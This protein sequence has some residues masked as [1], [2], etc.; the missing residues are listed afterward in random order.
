MTTAATRHV[1]ISGG[2]PSD[3]VESRVHADAD[4]LGGRIAGCRAVCRYRLYTR[5][6]PRVRIEVLL[7]DRKAAQGARLRGGD[8][9]GNGK[10]DTV[11]R[12]VVLDGECVGGAEGPRSIEQD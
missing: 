8:T 1:F 3:G 6:E 5:T 7:D 9:A 2:T 11:I 12:P 4:T 10:R